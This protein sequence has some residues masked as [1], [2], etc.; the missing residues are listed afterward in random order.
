MK[1]LIILIA[2]LTFLIPS[3]AYSDM[4]TIRLGYFMPNALRNLAAHPDSL[5]S[6]ELSQMSLLPSDFRGSILGGGYEFFL[7]KQISFALSIDLFNKENGGYYLDYVGIALDTP[8]DLVGDYAFPANPYAGET[9]TFDVLHTFHVTMT[10]I[11]FS[12]KLAPLGRKT[13]FIPYIGGGAG[14]Y[15]LSAS[16][17]GEIVDFGAP[18]LVNDAA[19]PE[20]GDFDIFPIAGAR[21]HETRA[22]LGYH[23]F[24]GL[25]VP[26]GYR[27]TLETEARYHVAK[28]R[29]QNAFPDYD[30]LDLS[31]ISL[32]VGLNY[33]F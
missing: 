24:A 33:W 32:S 1:K 8:P 12:L 21:A 17:V 9:G 28:A 31:G 20:L 23:A 18:Q 22:V 29:L 10:P 16:I 19:H 6:I 5:M 14:I 4:M 27:L 2:V 30:K 26:I 3:L 13:R 25:M 7:T 15:F 11:Q